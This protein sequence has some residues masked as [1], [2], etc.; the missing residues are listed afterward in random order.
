MES[1]AELQAAF[2]SGDEAMKQA[3][4]SAVEDGRSF[5]GYYET[6]PGHLLLHCIVHDSHHRGQ[7]LALLR[8]AGRPE[9]ERS[10]LEDLTWAIWR[11]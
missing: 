5:K 6:H 9:Q 7:I 10:E 3:V 2:D 11:E 8:Q 1:I 4:L